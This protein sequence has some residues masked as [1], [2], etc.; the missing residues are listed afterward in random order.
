MRN[1]SRKSDGETTLYIEV[2]SSKVLIVVLYVDD[3]IFIG[4][5]NFLIGEFKEAMENEFEMTDLVLLMYFLGIKVKQ[6]HDGIFVSQEKYAQIRSWRD[7]KFR[8]VRQLQHQ[9]H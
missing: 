2:E 8:T 9:Q 1:G 4:S 5:D 6:M 7:S 3:L